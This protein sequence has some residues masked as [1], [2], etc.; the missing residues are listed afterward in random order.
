M[1]SLSWGKGQKKEE[2]GRERTNFSKHK[3]KPILGVPGLAST[4]VLFSARPRRFL[5]EISNI[6]LEHRKCSENSSLD[7]YSAEN[8]AGCTSIKY[9]QCAYLQL[10]YP[11]RWHPEFTLLSLLKLPEKRKKKPTHVIHKK[12]L[13]HFSV[14]KTGKR[15]F[16]RKQ[17]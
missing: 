13:Q 17:C 5:K 10:P 6:Y 7:A 1:Q 2:L 3:I 14:P 15:P 9:Y 11:T 8:T 12:V 4:Q 16:L